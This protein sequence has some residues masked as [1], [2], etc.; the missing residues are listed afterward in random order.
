MKVEGRR[1]NTFVS[2]VAPSLS[3]DLR[4]SSVVLGLFAA[5]LA[6]LVYVNG[7]DNPFV[8]DD[9]DTVVANPS[10][11]DPSNIRFVL[12]HSPFRPVVNVSYAIDRAIWGYRPFGFHLTNVLLH[13]IVVALLYTLL[14]RALEDVRRRRAAGAPE[15]PRRK[16]GVASGRRSLLTDD[17]TDGWAAFTGAALYGVHPLLTEAVGYV[18]GRSE[19]L[20]GMFFL[21]ALLCARVAMLDRG[22]QPTLTFRSRHKTVVGF[23]YVA[24]VML[25]GALALLS[26]E[27][28]VV[29]P[30]V[31]LA[32][33]WIVLP[34][35]PEARR[36]R[37]RWIFVPV[38]VV[39]GLAAA[40]RLSMVSGPL[41]AETPFLNLLTQ[42]I[43]I[44]RYLGLLVVPDGQS[45]M[46][47]V[48]RVA[49]L[50]D[51]QGLIALA[52][53]FALAAAAYRLRRRQPLVSF[54]IVWFLAAIAPSSSVIALREG[55][56]EHRAY[57]AS[58]G[59]FV[60][61]SAGAAAL[62]GW[63]AQQRKGMHGYAVVLAGLVALLAALTYSRNEVWRSPVT[64]W[65]EA[66]VQAAGM[67]EPHYAL[68]DA[69]REA[70]DCASAIPEYEA[71]VRIRPGHRDAHTNLG[72]C[73]AEANRLDAA[74]AAFE[75]ALEID[76]QFARGYTNLGALALVSGQP[77]R[78]RDFYAMALE[79]DAR[80]VLARMQLARLLE[81]VF[82]DYH[83][84]ARMC[85]EAR[86]IAPDTP[87]VIACVERN[88]KLASDADGAR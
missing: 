53:L 39:F 45:I 82:H 88:Q 9:H 21:A 67:W 61:L 87:G 83:A 50:W 52:G 18:S 60:I 77:E 4:P 24:A 58:A 31:V 1:T 42:A 27:V 11:V 40:Y 57:I 59:A 26:K 48:H 14:V 38:I 30:L 22:L 74:Q 51:P 68:A 10:L 65:R 84:A 69:L 70:G 8:Y 3:S 2:S 85:G 73:L 66:T 78:A 81:T 20:C 54:G 37:L 19:L 32:Y 62:A 76:P 55:M 34:S 56:A 43:V 49:S 17:G 16:G 36:W 46:H 41:S 63:M 86:A 79:V 7:L 12:V 47:G 28:A 72:I 25:L 75:R 15:R 5:A 64:L 71:V 35:T 80:N 13:A 44:W 6:A 33:D 29:L 23:V